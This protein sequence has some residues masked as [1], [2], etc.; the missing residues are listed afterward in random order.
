MIK[1]NLFI[2]LDS[3]VESFYL[4]QEKSNQVLENPKVRLWIQ[5]VGY[6]EIPTPWTFAQLVK[7]VKSVTSCPVK[8]ILHLSEINGQ[9][10]TINNDSDVRTLVSYQMIYKLDWLALDVITEEPI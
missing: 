10:C 9:E 7:A 6:S 4:N 2:E 5:G 1:D 3:S 8:Q